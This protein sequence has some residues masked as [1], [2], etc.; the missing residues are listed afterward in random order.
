MKSGNGIKLVFIV[1]ALVVVV[2]LL[3]LGIK[4][5]SNKRGK[6]LAGEA[7]EKVEEVA[8]EYVA[9]LTTG[10]GTVYNGT[11]VLFSKADKQ[12]YK[13]FDT[14]YVLN[15]AYSYAINNGNASADSALYDYV[16]RTYHYTEF[17]I[18]SGE[19][20]RKGVKAIFGEDF[21]DTSAELFNFAYKFEYDENN[22]IYII[23]NN[24]VGVTSPNYS[25]YTKAISSV[26]KNKK[27][28]VDLV[29]AYVYANNGTYSFTKDVDLKEAVFNSEKFEMDD[30][31]VDTFDH[32]IVTLT[33]DGDN[34]VFESIQKK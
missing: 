24:Q 10:T 8:I 30:S 31:K 21:K 28:E 7:K 1:I 25:V 19:E 3:F 23:T 13:D 4:A 6:E 27:V 20:I 34:Y 17:D 15:A 32:Y 33:K 18:V 16:K 11:D 14:V 12:T 29:V 9:N 5:I 26:E 2:L 22:D